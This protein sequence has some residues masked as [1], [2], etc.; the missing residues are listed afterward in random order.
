[1]PL[2]RGLEITMFAVFSPLVQA[3]QGITITLAWLT[4]ALFLPLL[5]IVTMA[6]FLLPAYFVAQAVGVQ[7]Q[8]EAILH[9]LE[10][11]RGCGVYLRLLVPAL[12]M[13]AGIQLG[14]IITPLGLLAPLWNDRSW[15]IVVLVPAWI[16]AVTG[17]MWLWLSYARYF[18]ARVVGHQVGANP[19]H[20]SRRVYMVGLTLLLWALLAPVIIA[21]TILSAQTQGTG[22]PVIP[23]ESVPIA[24]AVSVGLLVIISLGTW[25]LLG[26]LRT[27]QRGQCA[28]CGADAPTGLIAGAVC[29]T[30]GEPLAAWLYVDYA[31]RDMA[32]R[33]RRLGDR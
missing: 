21:Q 32:L 1:M 10:A 3:N 11:R 8:R 26:L 25:G 15:L 30:C 29:A 14:L 12:L 33:V 18:G 23:Y 13:A 2:W 19:P 20:G 9:L 4:I 31:A 28:T 22:P 17:L 27:L 16:A 5:V 7:M 24:A 6:I